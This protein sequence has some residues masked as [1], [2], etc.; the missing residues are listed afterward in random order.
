MLQKNAL[1]GLDGPGEAPPLET[2]S[3]RIGFSI[4]W[5]PASWVPGLPRRGKFA[6]EFSHLSP[7]GALQ[8]RSVA[9]V[10]RLGGLLGPR[11]SDVFREGENSSAHFLLL[12]RPGALLGSPSALLGPSWGPLGPPVVREGAH[13]PACMSG[14]V[15]DPTGSGGRVAVEVHFQL[16]ARLSDSSSGR[17]GGPLGCLEDCFGCHA[18]PGRAGGILRLAASRGLPRRSWGSVGALLGFLEAS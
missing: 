9:A 7:W 14:G 12:G 15:P 16:G 4:L 3:C 17:G 5:G 18:Q 10:G 11:S 6:D 2:S 8:A 1:W 13:D